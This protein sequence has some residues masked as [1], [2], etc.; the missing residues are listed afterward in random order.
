MLPPVRHPRYLD[1]FAGPRSPRAT[2]IPPPNDTSAPGLSQ[3]VVPQPPV[4]DPC[5][6]ATSA[7]SHQQSWPHDANTNHVSQAQNIRFRISAGRYALG[8]ATKG[9]YHKDYAGSARSVLNRWL[10]GD[11]PTREKISGAEAAKMFGVSQGTISKISSGAQ[12]MTLIVALPLCQQLGI[13]LDDLMFREGS[14][15]STLRY[16]GPSARDFAIELDAIQRGSRITTKPRA[17]KK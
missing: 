1:R 14:P 6:S 10:L 8:M 15:D 4:K 3:T 11:N 17:R 5:S 9:A 7:I 16:A 2:M 13:T 12:Q